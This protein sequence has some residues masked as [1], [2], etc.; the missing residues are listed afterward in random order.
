MKPSP[1]LVFTVAF[2]IIAFRNS[3]E[4]LLYPALYVEDGM[5]LFPVF[6]NHHQI[7]DI[8]RYYAGYISVLPNLLAF[9]LTFLPLK[10]IPFSF[11]VVSHAVSALTFALVYKL[12]EHVY[13]NKI[14]AFYVA[15]IL[16]AF[17][18]GNSYLVGAL[19]FQ[20][21]NFVI[22]L[23]LLLLMPMPRG[24]AMLI[25]YNLSIHSLIWSNPAAALIVPICLYRLFKDGENRVS[26]AMFSLSGLLYFFVGIEHGGMDFS[27]AQF[28]V[29]AFV[30]RVVTEGIVG[31]LHR[32]QMTLAGV[33]QALVFNPIIFI[34]IAFLYFSWKERSAK[35]RE[36]LVAMIYLALFS[37][38]MP[39]LG[40]NLG[41]E[42][43]AEVWH[44]RYLYIPKILFF[45]LLLFSSYTL[46]RRYRYFRVGHFLFFAVCLYI[47]QSSQFLYDSPVQGGKRL[48]NF[49]DE[50]SEAESKCREG[51]ATRQEYM[52]LQRGKWTIK[53]KV[54]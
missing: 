7:Q 26:H 37:T 16:A 18:L 17:P 19:M 2:F 29:P 22:I 47:N 43:I 41:E 30:E 38:V 39:V 28:I 53:I 10:I 15:V 25:V 14:F 34:M 9:F 36:I 27:A 1:L 54:C 31:P 46:L 40:R 5:D 51:N 49:L 44:Q 24:P 6:Y 23:Y 45:I 12:T 13:Q 52:E 50:I 8:F 4:E 3:F 42:F 32:E 35:D 48:G 11:A 33:S 21:W 20:N